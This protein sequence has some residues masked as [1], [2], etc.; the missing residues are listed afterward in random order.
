MPQHI[1]HDGQQLF[2]ISA[3]SLETVGNE[4]YFIM[5]ALL[6]AV[7]QFGAD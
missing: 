5:Y 1:L 7:S 4:G 3:Y 2:D 6:N